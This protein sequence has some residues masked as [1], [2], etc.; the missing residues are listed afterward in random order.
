MRLSLDPADDAAH[1]AH[2]RHVPGAY[3]WW[4]FDA[5]SDDGLWM[6]ACIWF[7][8]NPFS[9]Y[10]RL[11]AA[12]TPADPFVHNALFF[13]LYNAG[14]L[15]AYHFTRFPRT[16]ICADEL[17]PATLRFGENHLT[18]NGGVYR[19]RL[20][21]ENANRR[22]L[23]AE[24]MFAPPTPDSGGARAEESPSPP[25]LPELG[26]G[27]A[28]HVWL[29]AAPTC[30]V[31]GQIAL[32]ERSNAGAEQITFAGDGYHDHNWGTLPFDAEVR[33]WYWARA[34]LENERAAIVYHV[35]RKEGPP[36]SHL[37][38]FE[39]GRLTRHDP[40]ATVARSR[41]R[42]NGFGTVYA[43]RL[44]VQSADTAAT[45]L[46]RQRLDSAPFY[47]RT[48]SEAM[49]TTAGRVETG[50]GLGEWFR[51]A[52]MSSPLAASAMKARIVDLSDD[53]S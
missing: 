50:R 21:D 22:R 20:A 51:P 53:G 27:G 31:S 18:F 32:R 3:E 26:A 42:V 8:G 37:L 45:F 12:R 6:L 2:L 19:L 47:V 15:Y 29:P 36:D 30:R 23:T 17:R 35:E 24:L 41:W 44:D 14:Q 16:Q 33:D 43:T 11:A 52:L 10:A 5:L 38:L 49:V 28:S 25:A 7:L 13:A 40:Q 48:L 1:G 46:L 34:T 39:N 9:P 4:Y